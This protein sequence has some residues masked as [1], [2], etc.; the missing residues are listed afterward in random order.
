MKRL[1]KLHWEIRVTSLSNLLKQVVENFTGCQN[2]PVGVY[3]ISLLK[4]NKTLRSLIKS[5][6][7][8]L[9]ILDEENSY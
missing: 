4:M 9:M 5:V 6:I 7:K 1:L 2:I 3:P 8:S